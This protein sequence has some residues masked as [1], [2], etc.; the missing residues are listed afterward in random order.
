MKGDIQM[1]IVINLDE[2]IYTRLFDNGTLISRAD[3]IVIERAIRAGIV[4]PK[5][6]GR[7]IDADVL[8]EDVKKHYF[9]N[10][11]AL[12]CVEIPVNNAPTILESNKEI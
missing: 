10:R 12:R 3:G 7:L 8:M 2:N 1:Q 11:S 5:G 4:L 9:D 6:H